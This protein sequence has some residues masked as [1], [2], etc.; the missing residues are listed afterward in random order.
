VLT[1]RFLL[2]IEEKAILN[3]RLDPN[4]EPSVH[5]SMS[6]AVQSVTTK[7]IGKFNDLIERCQCELLNYLR[8]G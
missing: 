3:T 8:W 2:P 5:C 4:F 1:T 7:G 6:G